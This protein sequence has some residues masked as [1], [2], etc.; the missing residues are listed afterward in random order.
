MWKC[1]VF[2]CDWKNDGASGGN[3]DHW[4]G[5][6][7]VTARS[8]MEVMVVAGRLLVR[9]VITAAAVVVVA[10]AVKMLVGSW[11]Q[12]WLRR[13]KDRYVSLVLEGICHIR[14]TDDFHSNKL[15]NDVVMFLPDSFVKKAL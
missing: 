7:A 2:S 4:D 12:Q 13:W 6:V 15:F 9:L 14:K 10:A 11:A 3:G 8:V 1:L 5:H